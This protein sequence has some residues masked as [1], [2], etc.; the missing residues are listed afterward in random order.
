MTQTSKRKKN[1]IV[2]MALVLVCAVSVV[3]TLAYLTQKADPVTNTF[4][5]AGGGVIIDPIRIPAK[6]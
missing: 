2:I 3:G 6:T 5:A 1:L 4:V